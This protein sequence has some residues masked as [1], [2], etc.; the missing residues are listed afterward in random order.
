MNEMIE[1]VAR[2]VAQRRGFDWDDLPEEREAPKY[3]MPD[4]SEFR[5]GARLHMEA[6]REPTEAM[7]AAGDRVN[8]D[9]CMGVAV[10]P[11]LIWAAMIGAALK[12]GDNGNSASA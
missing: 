1:R 10:Y 8:D 6:M 9:H 4:R 2:I 5:E 11:S 7:E 12:E 3:G